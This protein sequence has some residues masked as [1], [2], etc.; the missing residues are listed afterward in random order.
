[1]ASVG[2]TQQ[3][4]TKPAL[5]AA[6]R[7]PRAPQARRH[8]LP[9]ALEVLTGSL[10]LGPLAGTGVSA[11]DRIT[12]VLM[13]LTVAL[14]L[15]GTLYRTGSRRLAPAPLARRASPQTSPHAAHRPPV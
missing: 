8:W 12:L 6:T 4:S 2:A 15:I 9:L 13:H 10:I 3:A 11:D 14:T 1:M 7:A 5:A